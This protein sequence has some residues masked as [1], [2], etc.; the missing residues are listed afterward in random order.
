MTARDSA[1]QAKVPYSTWARWLASWC[2]RGVAGI[3]RVAAKAHAGRAYRVDPGLVERWLAGEL[4]SP[5]SV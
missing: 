2:A 5:Y 4:P 3:E 1:T